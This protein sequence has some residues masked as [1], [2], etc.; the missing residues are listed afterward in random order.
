MSICLPKQGTQVRPL[1][2]EDS[3]DQQ[4]PRTTTADPVFQSPRATATEAHAPSTYAPQPEKP[5]Q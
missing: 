2:Q 3:R 5:L 4:S 1:V